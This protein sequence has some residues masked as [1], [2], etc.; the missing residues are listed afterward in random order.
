MVCYGEIISYQAQG[1]TKY[2][3]VVVVIKT[4]TYYTSNLGSIQIHQARQMITRIHKMQ[5]DEQRQRR[6]D[7]SDDDRWLYEHARAFDWLA[8]KDEINDVQ[9]YEAAAAYERIAAIG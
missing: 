6:D 5:S 9:L 3:S 2:D 1:S 7:D 8:N 4:R